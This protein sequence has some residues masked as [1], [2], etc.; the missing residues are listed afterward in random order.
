MS[1]HDAA[2]HRRVFLAGGIA[3][4]LENCVTYPFEM[5]KCQLQL[6]QGGSDLFKKELQYR[7]TS[8]CLT[9]TFREKG[10]RGVYRGS[11]S[12]FLFAFPRSAVRFSIYE[13]LTGAWTDSGREQ[14]L[15][16]DGAAGTVAGAVEGALCQT[17]NQAIQIKIVRHHPMLLTIRA[18]HAHAMRMC[19]PR[20]A[21]H[22][23][24]P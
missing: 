4:I 11:A 7:N 21:T 15:W 24:N 23:C 10:W 16:A 22:P 5:A 17:P 18:M 6:Q 9:D 19:H 1:T 3:G 13:Q 14:T 20:A 2:R 12:W 8:H